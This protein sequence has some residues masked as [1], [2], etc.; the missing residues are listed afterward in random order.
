MEDFKQADRY[1]RA[2][3]RVTELKGFYIHLFIYLCMVPVFIWL[4]FRSTSFPWAIFPIAGWGI[5]IVGHA[6][7]AFR[8]N[9]F[10][11]KNWEERKIKEFMSDEENHWKR[12]NHSH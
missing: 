5:G 3:E 11:S 6:S 12:S 7:E 9:P 4:N 10:F 1:L 8:W 2:K